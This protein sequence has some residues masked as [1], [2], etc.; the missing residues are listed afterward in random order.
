MVTVIVEKLAVITD[1]DE[2]FLEELDKLCKKYVENEGD[3]YL[4]YT[5]EG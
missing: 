5:V 4:S 3:Y 2:Q 1:E